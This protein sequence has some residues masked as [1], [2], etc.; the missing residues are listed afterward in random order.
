MK[1]WIKMPIS[2]AANTSV[3]AKK[4]PKA[5][6]VRVPLFITAWSSRGLKAVCPYLF[7]EYKRVESD[8]RVSF[9]ANFNR[10]I[11]GPDGDWHVCCKLDALSLDKVLVQIWFLDN[12]ACP[13]RLCTLH[14]RREPV[15]VPLQ[16]LIA[17]LSPSKSRDAYLYNVNVQ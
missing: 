3:R 10:H 8:R 6:A 12:C 16:W 2:G 13:L 7:M 9:E 17:T 1:A 11:D 14:N 4:F 15:T 5:Q